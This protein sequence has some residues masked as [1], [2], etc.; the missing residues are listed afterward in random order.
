MDTGAYTTLI[1][2]SVYRG[3]FQGEPPKL[4]PYDQRCYSASLDKM[5]ILGKTRCLVSTPVGSFTT[6]ALVYQ[7]IMNQGPHLLIGSN[8]MDAIRANFPDRKF[9]FAPKKMQSNTGDDHPIRLDFRS[10]RITGTRREILLVFPEEKTAPKTAYSGSALAETP[11][12]RPPSKKTPPPT[13]NQDLP[14]ETATTSRSSPSQKPL[15]STHSTTAVYLTQDLEIPPQTLYITQSSINKGFNKDQDLIV[16]QNAI[17]GE[18]MDNGNHYDGTRYHEVMIPNLCTRITE[19]NT[20]NVHIVNLHDKAILVRAGTQLGV[21]EYADFSNVINEIRDQPQAGTKNTSVITQADI[22]CGDPTAVPRLLSLL[23]RYRSALWLAGDDLGHYTGEQLKIEQDTKRVVNKPPY[24]I[25][26][27]LQ[28]PLDEAI[29]GMLA[30]GIIT[31]SKSSY[32]SPLILVKKAG[33]GIRPCL[34]LRELNKTIKPVSYPLPRIS[35]LLNSLGEAKVM[36]TCD[37]A[38]AYTQTAIAPED[39]EKTAFTVGTTKYQFNRVP[40]GIQSAPG[41]FSRV[42][43]EVLFKI[44][45]KSVLAYLDDLILFNCNTEQHFETIEAVL[46]ALDKANLKLKLKK[47]TFFASQIKF[48]GYK[49]TNQ[50]MTMDPDRVVAISAMPMP[51]NKK[52]LQAFLGVC[53]YYRMFVHNFATIADPLY[54]LLRKNKKFV[55]TERQAEAVQ[56]LKTSLA[57]APIV[58]FPDYKKPFHIHS[59]ASSSGV[60]AVLMQEEDGLL[61]PLAYAS[62]TLNSAQRHYATT[63]KEALA[64]V[65][66]LEQFRNIILTYPITVYTDHKPLLGA[67]FK[68]TRDECLQRWAILVQEYGI[69]LKYIEGKRNIFADTFSRL[70]EPTSVELDQHFHEE[71]ENRCHHISDFLPLKIPWNEDQLRDSQHKDATCLDILN[72]LKGKIGTKKVHDHLLKDCKIIQGIVHIVRRIPRASFDDV[73]LVPYVPD[74]LMTDALRVSHED[75]TAGHKGPERT[76]KLFT[77]NFYNKHER[78]LITQFC[79]KCEVCIRAKGATK[80][81]PLKAYPIPTRPFHTLSSDIVGPLP[82]TEAGNKYIVT[83]RDYVTRFTILYPL[84]NKST[85][86]IIR[87]LRRVFA[88]HGAPYVFLTDRGAE[89][90]SSDLTNF[91][92]QYNTRKAEVA[93]YHASSHGFAERINREINKLLRMF[94]DR[95]ELHNWDEYLPFIQICINDT[96]NASLKETPFFAKNSY[97]GASATYSPPR[98]NLGE[99]EL[100]QH[101]QKT[102]QIREVC[103]DHLLQAQETYTT[104]ANKGR[105]EKHIKVGQRVFAKIEKHQQQP[106][107]KLDLPVSGPFTVLSKNGNAWMLEEISTG[108]KYIVHADYMVGRSIFEEPGEGS[109]QEQGEDGEDDGEEDEEEDGEE[110]EEEDGEEDE[111]EDEGEEEEKKG[112]RVT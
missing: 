57:T 36:S 62:K 66:A 48:L 35:D 23:N 76:L 90:T 107:K 100:N 86:D 47:C 17:I 72:Q 79:D 41:Y 74:R 109:E 89:Y 33:G 22:T 6:E 75:L 95:G 68:P 25:P 56:K 111:E 26:H 101:M 50:G 8:I 82:V 19:N 20:I 46:Q 44:L 3:L 15:A 10:K 32:N 2:E 91:L 55:W 98:L 87:C 21:A 106:R 64:L 38:A 88:D 51:K 11:Q 85:K 84:P 13:S 103:R 110:D 58:R 45:G 49:V 29:E 37:L 30:E 1:S 73:V 60:A 70:P 78:R 27:A 24:R 77:K 34:D 94:T 16:R 14:Q 61:H 104:Q 40:F 43:N 18:V 63:K 28:A 54:D 81:V 65:F 9:A 92:Q 99:D 31:P 83:F 4:T 105:K 69:Q 53:N 108:K 39:R 42:I 97:D 7:R 71:L 93:P 102:A 12:L 80:L 5:P 67:L 96:Y 112:T 59:D 52:N